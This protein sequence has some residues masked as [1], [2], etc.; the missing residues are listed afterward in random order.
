MAVK[1]EK[2]V[3]EDLNTGHGT[4]ALTNPGGGTMVGNKI[5]L[6]T[7]TGT[8]NVKDFGATGDGSTDDTTAI[9]LALTA[10]EAQGGGR[11]IFAAPATYI[12][13][14]TGFVLSGNTEIEIPSGASIKI[15]N[16]NNA[17]TKIF[18]ATS[19][20]NVR[21]FGG[22]SI[23]GNESNQTSGKQYGVFFHSVDNGSV[24]NVEI[25]N[26]YDPTLAYGDGIIIDG[27]NPNPS[28]N[29]RLADLCIHDCDRQAVSFTCAD[30]FVLIN[31][32]FY[33]IGYTGI[34][35]E[36]DSGATRTVKNGVISNGVINNCGFVGIGM[37]EASGVAE[38]ENVTVSNVKILN[39]T[40]STSH[41]N[42]YGMYLAGTKDCKVSNVTVDTVSTATS[43]IVI[44][45]LSTIPN[46]NEGLII[47]NCL[48]KNCPNTG[49]WLYGESANHVTKITLRGNTVT[50]TSTGATGYGILGDYVDEVIL[51][52]N[53]TTLS[54][55][56]GVYFDHSTN[57][58]LIGN[59]S[60][61]NGTVSSGFGFDFENSSKITIGANVA[62]DTSDGTQSHGLR[63]NV[64]DDIIWAADNDFDH[65]ATAAI[66]SSSLSNSHS[67]LI[68]SGTYT[69]IGPGN[70]IP[71]TTLTVQNN[72]TGGSTGLYVIYGDTQAAVAPFTI[73]TNALAPKFGVNVNGDIYFTSQRGIM[74]YNTLANGLRHYAALDGSEAGA[75]AGSDLIFFAYSDAGAALGQTLKLVR[76]NL[77]LVHLGGGV[78]VGAPTG[79]AK[80]AGTINVAGDIYKNNTAYNSPDY[81]FDSGYALMGVDELSGFIS[82]NKHLPGISREPCGMF[83][84]GDKLLEKV[85]ELTLYVIDLHN[86]IK[87]L[88]GE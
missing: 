15:K 48:V 19:I 40:S 26:I 39:T 42:A 21:I 55:I 62:Y 83:E 50:G 11:L 10:L 59:K 64:C 88:K 56:S 17:T 63:I 69:S 74:F 61:G 22:G 68:R 1:Y 4:T 49:I 45:C 87:K 35:L 12:V 86:Q 58:V 27:L 30:D 73:L 71:Q 84:R 34:D 66:S 80:G 24:E 13:S 6:H 33:D 23:D 76:S 18:S 31:F 67:H 36:P 81:V 8:F 78:V 53:I 28:T 38:V 7:F 32:N 16:S 46:G 52:N 5:G 77:S 65:N 70:P 54:A 29:I 47:E 43:G 60:F 44:A 75:N 57:I 85:E 20:S 41:P 14:G 37:L 51:Q 3:S 2:I 82:E 25:K 79:G 9:N 72:E